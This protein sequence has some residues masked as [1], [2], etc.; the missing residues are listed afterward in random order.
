MNSKTRS[1]DSGG[2][3]LARFI[4]DIMQT[5]ECRES[6]N[7]FVNECLTAVSGA[8]MARKTLFRPIQWYVSKKLRKSSDILGDEELSRLFSQPRWIE[9]A[10]PHIPE[11]INGI[12]K[13]IATGLTAF[14]NMPQEKQ[15]VF[16]DQLTSKL[17]AGTLGDIITSLARTAGRMLESDPLFFS[18]R[19]APLLKN[20]IAQTDF[21]E[22]RTYVEQSETDIKD[23]VKQVVSIFF[24]YPVKII[25]LLGILPSLGNILIYSIDAIL[26]KFISLPP[27]MVSDIILA[28]L[29]EVNGRDM[30]KLVNTINEF[31]RQVHTGSAL[32]GEPG[33]P[34]FSSDIAV[35][36]REIFEETDPSLFVK[37]QNALAGGKDAMARAYIRAREAHPELLIT[38]LSNWSAPINRWVA[39]RKEK[40]MVLESL[41]ETEIADALIKG[42]SGVNV[43]DLTEIINHGVRL[44]SQARAAD[45]RTITSIAK[46][47]TNGLDTYEME[48]ALPDL[49]NEVGTALKP[50]VRIAMPA[51]T[52]QIIGFFDSEA[53]GQDDRMNEALAK[54][55]RFLSDEKVTS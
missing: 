38:G 29:R 35:K 51:V 40:M 25:N 54:W 24:D 11:L 8:S 12:L 10:G 19:L 53:D 5:R 1:P 31:I 50:M 43:G 33:A 39:I 4:I 44:I 16:F 23:M 46:E 21:G 27:D 22:I 17:D 55:R 47:L 32:I 13:I 42:L 14:E 15:A 34:L 9:S 20:L 26:K 41:D 3:T 18:E 2:E 7:G 36:S 49:I 28:V 52:D 37:A 45:A 30:G 6:I 48:E